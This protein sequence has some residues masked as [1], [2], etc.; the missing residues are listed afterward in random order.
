MASLLE[1]EHMLLRNEGLVAFNL[2]AVLGEE[3]AAVSASLSEE[4]VLLG[5]WRIASSDDSSPELLANALTLLLQLTQSD[6]GAL[7]YST[8]KQE[9]TA[10]SSP[11][12]PFF[13]RRCALVCI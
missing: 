12:T 3:T 4:V 1:S 13:L 10:F 8:C 7:T 2:L 11:N 6:T 9:H 5:V